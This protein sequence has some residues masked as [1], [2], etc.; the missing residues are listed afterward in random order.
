MNVVSDAV[1]LG[2]DYGDISEEEKTTVIAVRLE[3]VLS[4]LK[5]QAK[6]DK[7]VDIRIYAGLIFLSRQHR[8]L[9]FSREQSN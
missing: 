1:V 3:G 9:L 4:W 6:A 8:E 5:E 7:A 2:E